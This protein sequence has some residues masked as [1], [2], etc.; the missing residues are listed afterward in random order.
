MNHLNSCKIL[1]NQRD[2]AISKVKLIMVAQFQGKFYLIQ[3][4]TGFHI[5]INLHLLSKRIILPK[6]IL[7]I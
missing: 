2:F 6:H 5:N 7:S 3:N 1:K 4:L